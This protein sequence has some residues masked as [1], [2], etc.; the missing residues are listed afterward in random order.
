[1]QGQERILAEHVDGLERSDFCDFDKPRKR[2]NQKGK[3]RVQTS[4]AR[5]EVSRNKFVEKGGEPDR[6]KSFPEIDSRE[7]HPRARPGF[8]Q[9]I[10]NELRKEQNLI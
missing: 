1:M 7:D 10:R 3:I 2:A 9:P 8:V 5:S 4:K 6:V